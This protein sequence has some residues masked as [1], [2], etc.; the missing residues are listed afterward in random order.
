[1][2]R[3]LELHGLLNGIEV[4]GLAC[5]NKHQPLLLGRE[6]ESIKKS[7]ATSLAVVHRTD[8]DIAGDQGAFDAM[9]AIAEC[10]YALGIVPGNMF[11][12]EEVLALLVNH[13]SAKSSSEGVEY[14]ID[15][16]GAVDAGEVAVFK[17]FFCFAL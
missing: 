10:P 5:A 4:E 16:L 7:S 13:A 14:V 6:T 3:K 12:V 9:I 11:V 8:V 1:M 17:F 2:I 15:T